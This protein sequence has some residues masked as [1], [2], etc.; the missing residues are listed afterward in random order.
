M[1]NQSICIEIE[2]GRRVHA[3]IFGDGISLT[4]D[5]PARETD[6]DETFEQMAEIFDNSPKKPTAFCYRRDDRMMTNIHLTMEMA[7]ATMHAIY[8]VIERMRE[9]KTE[10]ANAD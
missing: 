7:E 8:E 5:R 2:N 9:S 1:G 6:V 4:F 10:A 3:R